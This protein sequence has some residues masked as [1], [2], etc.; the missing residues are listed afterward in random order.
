M[1]TIETETRTAL[2]VHYDGAFGGS[3][4]QLFRQTDMRVNRP[5]PDV[6]PDARAIMSAREEAT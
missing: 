1:K 3:H 6:I 4:I 5:L 2:I